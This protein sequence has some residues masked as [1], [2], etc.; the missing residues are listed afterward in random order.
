MRNRGHAL[1]F[2]GRGERLGRAPRS[3]RPRSRKPD[4]DATICLELPGD[5]FVSSGYLTP[6]SILDAAGAPLARFEKLP[7][8]TWSGP[9]I[10][11]VWTA[12]GRGALLDEGLVLLDSHGRPERV[13]PVPCYLGWE[14]RL[15]VNG[16][17]AVVSCL[18]RGEISLHTFSAGTWVR[19]ELAGLEMEDGWS[20][21]LSQDGEELLAVDWKTYTLRRYPLR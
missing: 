5:R 1:R 16:D 2:D 7:D 13:V 19:L 10:D 12:D 20:V 3:D 14:P 15:A 17:H 6:L 9:V 8:G 11:A 21:G 18:I 4:S